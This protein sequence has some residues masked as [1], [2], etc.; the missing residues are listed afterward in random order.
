MPQLF[1]LLQLQQLIGVSGP[2]HA[3]GKLRD[4]AM[5]GGLASIVCMHIIP[6]V[7]VTYAQYSSGQPESPKQN[8]NKTAPSTEHR[9]MAQRNHK[10]IK[11]TKRRG[12]AYAMPMPA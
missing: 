6:L 1:N 9:G 7:V 2:K 4:M 5:T 12:S 11:E 8:A 10:Q 3:R